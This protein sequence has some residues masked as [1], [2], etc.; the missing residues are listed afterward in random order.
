MS[1][2]DDNYNL[3]F[4][5]YMAAEMCVEWIRDWFENNGNGCKAVIGISGG[6][7]SSVVAA[8]CVKALGKERVF[9]VLMPNGEQADINYANELCEFLGINN[10]TI[11]IESVY[12]T[13]IAKISDVLETTLSEQTTINLPA[14]LRMATL[15]AVSQTVG[16]RVINTCNYS[17]DYI[18]YA[19]RYGDGAGD[20]A[21]LAKF[22]VQE[23]KSIG[24]F[25]GLPEKFIEKTPSDGLCGKTDEDNLGFSYDTLDKYIR[26]GVLSKAEIKSKIDNLHKK[27]EFKLKPMPSFDYIITV[28]RQRINRARL[29]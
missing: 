6:K 24:R 9:G 27:N 18:G 14:R 22:T 4:N 17:E 12:D 13:A 2:N 1:Y 15:Y 10:V 23:V 21:P 19:T 20:M 26:Y 25:L 16:G 11:N 3:D 8:L 29:L 5:S 7:D 28:A